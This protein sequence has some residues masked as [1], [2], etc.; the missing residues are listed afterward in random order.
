MSCI[1]SLDSTV[2]VL[3]YRFSQSLGR[4]LPRDMSL[5]LTEG[6]EF[7]SL[8]LDYLFVGEETHQP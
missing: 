1:L 7:R 8:R 6:Q 2:G 3:E 4:H 5:C